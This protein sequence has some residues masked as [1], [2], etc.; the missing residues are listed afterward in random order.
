MS[1]TI[2]GLIITVLGLI[3]S[4]LKIDITQD[5]IVHIVT[6]A[7]TVYGVLH[8]YWGRYRQGDITWYGALLNQDT[9]SGVTNQ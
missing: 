6:V 5:Q 7:V 1:Q 4:Q 8:T 9:N 2:I 3:A